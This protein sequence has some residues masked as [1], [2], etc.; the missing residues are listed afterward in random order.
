[1]EQSWRVVLGEEFEKPYFKLLT[2]KVRA[3]YTGGVP[4]Y[5]PPKHIF[6]A[7]ELCPFGAARVVILG[8]DPYHGPHQAHGLCFSVNDGVPLPPSLKNIYRELRDDLGTP[9]SE[10]GDLTNWGKQGVLLLNATLTVHAGIAGS[11][12]GWG[13]EEFTDAVIH[14]I[15]EKNTHVVFLLWGKYAQSKRT[16]IDETKHLVL[17]A[18]HPS[19]LSARNGF[20]G[21]RHFSKT[22]AYLNA[23][24]KGEISW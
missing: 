20:F 3:A 6:R 16:L 1:M 23:H 9:I 8:Q 22:N 17:T 19:P 10:N 4:V 24:G 14:A 15:S 21:C 11:H 12:Q 7:F 18:A 5:P 2:E 13:W